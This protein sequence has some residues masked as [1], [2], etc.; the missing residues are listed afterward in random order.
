MQKSVK[1]PAK[2]SIV[3]EDPPNNLG[4]LLEALFWKEPELAEHAES[5]L[6]HIKEWQRTDSPYTTD[7][8]DNYC[9]RTGLS[10]SQYS[11]M[12]K[13]LRKAGMIEKTYNKTRKRHE[14]KLSG[15]F[16]N[17]AFEMSRVWQDFLLD[18]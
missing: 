4:E 2:I 6:S 1:S 9:K 18:Y 5:F 10:Q 8:W 11:N 12:L 17:A 16:S 7:G 14:L 13:R 3:P 15:L